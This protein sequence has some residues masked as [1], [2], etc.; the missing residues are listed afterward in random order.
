LKHNLVCC[1]VYG[2]RYFDACVTVG[3]MVAM[4]SFLIS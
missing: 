3:G 2:W 1:G 4:L